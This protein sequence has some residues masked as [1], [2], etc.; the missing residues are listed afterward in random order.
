MDQDEPTIELISECTPEEKANNPALCDGIDET[1]ILYN[2]AKFYYA[3]NELLGAIVSYS[4][5]AISLNWIIKTTQGQGPKFVESTKMLNCCLNA[6]EVL[7]QKLAT[8][9]STGDDKDD[10]TKDWD[11]ICINNEPLTFIK[12]SSDCIFFNDV[13]GLH[14]EKKLLEASLIY[15]L[16]YPNLYP[17]ASRGILIYGPPGTGK[18]FMIKAAVNELQIQDPTVGVLYFAPSPSDL[19]GKYVGETEKKIEEIFTCASRAACKYQN[20]YCTDKKYISIIFMDEMDSIAPDRSTDT[21]GMAGNS[22]NTLLQMMDGIKSF[23]NVAVI[24]ATNYPWSLDAA[25]LRRFDTQLLIGLPTENDLKTLLDLEMNRAI[26]LDSD[27]SKFNYCREQADKEKEKS[28][29]KEKKKPE[30]KLSCVKTTVKQLYLEQPYSQLEF[31]YFS[32]SKKEIILAIIVKL[33]KSHFSNSDLNRLIKSA[34]TY[35]GELA[36]KNNLFYS[37][38]MLKDFKSNKFISCLTKIKDSAFAIK[39]SIKILNGWFA[40]D[41]T[42]NV[43][44]YQVKPPKN[45]AITYGAF[46]YVN[47][48]ALFYKNSDIIIDDPMVKDIYIKYRSSDANKIVHDNDMDAAVELYANNIFGMKYDKSSKKFTNYSV[49]SQAIDIILTLNYAFKKTSSAGNSPNRIFPILTNLINAVFKPINNQFNNIKKQIKSSSKVINK[50]SALAAAAPALAAAAPALAAAAPAPPAPFNPDAYGLKKIK[51]KYGFDNDDLTAINTATNSIITDN[52]NFLPVVEK[53]IA[54]DN[55]ELT[56]GITKEFSKYFSDHNFDFYHFLILYYQI[57]ATTLM[58]DNPIKTKMSSVT[59]KPGADNK[60]LNFAGLYLHSLDK[61][62]DITLKIYEVDPIGDDKNIAKI[63]EMKTSDGNSV[64]IIL[65]DNFDNNKNYIIQVSEFFKLINNLDVYCS[66]LLND[67]MKNIIMSIND[68]Y[69]SIPENI[70][71]IIFKNKIKFNKPEPIFKDNDYFGKTTEML[72]QLY[73][74]NLLT[75]TNLYKKIYPGFESGEYLI[76]RLGK[77]FD[78]VDDSAAPA[79]ENPSN[80]SAPLSLDQKTKKDAA[81]A[82]GQRR[83]AAKSDEER[84]AEEERRIAAAEA[85]GQ[86]RVEANAVAAQKIQ[87]G[88]VQQVQGKIISLYKLSNLVLDLLYDNFNLTGTN[89]LNDEFINKTANYAPLQLKITEFYTNFLSEQIVPDVNTD[90]IRSKELYIKTTFNFKNVEK[91]RKNGQLISLFGYIKKAASGVINI[92][93]TAEKKEAAQQEENLKLINLYNEKDKL[94]PLLFKE[95]TA[96]GFMGNWATISSPDKIIDD[97]LS[98]QNI[99]WTKVEGCIGILKMFVTLIKGFFATSGAF[100][101]N[102]TNRLIALSAAYN[103]LGGSGGGIIIGEFAAGVLKA[104]VAMLDAIAP[105]WG[106]TIAS[107]IFGIGLLCNIYNWYT[108][109]P[110]NIESEE[111][112]NSIFVNMFFELVT[113]K[114][115]SEVDSFNSKNPLEI[116]NETIIDLIHSQKNWFPSLSNAFQPHVNRTDSMTDKPNIVANVIPY[117]V[118]GTTYIINAPIYLMPVSENIIPNI[119][120]SLTNLNIPVQAFYYALHHVNST[121]NKQLVDDLNKYNRN[122]DEFLEELKKRK[123]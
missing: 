101:V 114:G 9:K 84:T 38:S 89:D 10:E 54:T 122:K 78:T 75:S 115:Y 39:Q 69:I 12:G 22:V 13:A 36:V 34:A 62:S 55:T 77:I 83:D 51:A 5:A 43:D 109:D 90:V 44:I 37:T 95:I 60:N 31:E 27:K 92:A 120:N 72:T 56:F 76:N 110:T 35:T 64:N 96:I 107:G 46:V 68:V 105:G 123:T 66:L 108:S 47:I 102:L 14:K 48:K 17:K 23:P 42:H 32:D 33:Y 45:F 112:I 81:V 21:T 103:L 82:E 3:S 113:L 85:E 15:P 20:E 6:I 40:T 8:Q 18:T 119:K 88:I 1:N 67:N 99:I 25:I 29:T 49:F 26:K 111:I 71:L 117:S 97:S 58:A 16:V 41:K 7:Q 104:P 121:Y 28:D 106:T 2:N 19:K 98:A 73:I 100:F 74:D 57:Y 116:L 94:L 61:W 93:K 79:V 70:F 52:P 87:V 4:C 50:V 80:S 118:V 63:E 59:L 86:R 91:L 24:G 65:D 11:K 53:I 30:C